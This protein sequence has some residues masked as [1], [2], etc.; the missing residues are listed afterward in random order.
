[1]PHIL[2]HFEIFSDDPD[3]LADFYRK[4]FGWKIADAMD[5]YKFIDTGGGKDAVGG[6]IERRKSD[7]QIPIN[8]FMVESIELIINKIKEAGGFIIKD[9]SPVPNYGYFAL[10]KDPSNNIF[11]IFEPDRKAK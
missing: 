1:M 10:I 6:G 9:K 7:D 3:K 2:C 4:I 11:G 8:Y 5:G